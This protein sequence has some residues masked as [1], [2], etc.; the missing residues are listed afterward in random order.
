MGQCINGYVQ[1][2]CQVGTLNRTSAEAE[3]RAVTA[4]DERMVVVQSH[5]GRSQEDLRLA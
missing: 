3:E 5:V 4:F 1:F 2:M